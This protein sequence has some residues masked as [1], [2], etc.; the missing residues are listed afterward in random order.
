MWLFWAAAAMLAAAVSALVGLAGVRAAKAALGGEDAAV[1][2]HRRQLEELDELA[3]RGLLDPAELDA[4]RAEAGRRLLSAAD[5]GV[6]AETAKRSG[7]IIIAA[8]VVLASV[9]A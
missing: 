4:V 5:A 8:G 7:R 9:L 3:Q 2:V 1:A 6:E